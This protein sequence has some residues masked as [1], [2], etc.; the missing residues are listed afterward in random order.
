MVR[1]TREKRPARRENAGPPPRSGNC[2][3]DRKDRDPSRKPETGSWPVLAEQACEHQSYDLASA[4]KG[5]EPADAAVPLRLRMG[6]D[7]EEVC[8]RGGRGQTDAGEER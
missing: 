3:D 5:L 2:R 6:L 4:I 8:H 1:R 7:D